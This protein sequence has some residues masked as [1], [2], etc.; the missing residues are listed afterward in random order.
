MPAPCAA[1]VEEDYDQLIVRYAEKLGDLARWCGTQGLVDEAAATRQVL[2]PS[3]DYQ[4][5]LVLL[6]E[7]LA[8]ET[9]AAEPTPLVLEWQQKL[10]DLKK[11]QAASLLEL[12]HKAADEK[13]ATRGYRLVLEAAQLDPN[14]AEAR[15]ILGYVRHEDRWLTPYAVE[16][17]KSRQVWHPQFGWVRQDRVARLEKGERYQM[18]RW[19]SADEDARLHAKIDRGWEVLTEHYQVRTNHSLEEGVRLAER[20][21]RLH[22]AWRQL[23][24]RYYMTEP[25]LGRLL[26]TGSPPKFG[27]RMRVLF[28]RNKDEYVQ[29]LVKAQPQIAITSGY[30]AGDRKEAYFFATEGEPDYSNRYH[31]ATHQL[32]NESR[33]VVSEVGEEAN[34]WIVEGIACY[35]ESLT[36]RGTEWT[37]GGRDA[38]RLGDARFR[39]LEDNFY[40][41][42][43]EFTGLG[44]VALQ[45][46]PRIA[47]LYSQSSGLTHY[48][49]HYENGIYRDALVDYLIAIY[50]G[51]ARLGT[52]GEL[53][54][55]GSD[56]MDAEYRRFLEASR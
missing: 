8:D 5:T 20:L 38:V 54:N 2:K 12:A 1:T 10:A 33:S 30:Y 35:M 44:R 17:A 36:Q 4:L 49:M 22:R 18:G 13:Q 7:P 26:K 16:K 14:L 32:F 34:F 3:D 24:V 27:K 55:R 40:V 39:L 52:L 6:D 11:V 19:I 25:Q 45:R 46:D 42:L 41:P 47:M 21:E 37:V 15:R 51:R 56:E 9:Q 48:L 23:F 50:T 31:E 29:H 43:N 53:T 28:F